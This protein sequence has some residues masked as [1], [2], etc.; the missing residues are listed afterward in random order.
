[1]R[2]LVTGA[3]GNVGQAAVTA[4]RAAEHEVVSTDLIGPN[5]DALAHE[6]D[7]E[8]IQADLRNPGDAFM[9]VKR[10]DV[11][12][13]CAAVPTPRNNTP[14]HVFTN[15]LLATFNLAEA[16]DLLGVKRI[17]NLSSAAVAEFSG[18]EHPILPPYLPIDENQRVE[19]RNPYTLA[20]YFGEQIMA[21]LARRSNVDCISLRPCWVQRPHDYAMKI[22]PRLRRPEFR[23]SRWSYVDLSDLIDAIMLSVDSGLPGHEVFYIAAADNAI[24]QPLNSLVSAFISDQLPIRPLPRPDASPVSYE[25]ARRLLGYTPERTWRD[26]LQPD[27]EPR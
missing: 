11:V 6:P 21:S 26:Y 9:I 2:I 10:C 18:G 14:H 5:Y 7:V 19:P 23:P 4:L 20:K 12:I 16:A 17:V 13:H 22:G 3:R 8:Y 27:G 25:K 24:G 15:N 1:L